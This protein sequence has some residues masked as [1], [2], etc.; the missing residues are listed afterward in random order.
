MYV[1]V[2]TVRSDMSVRVIT[3][4]P[5]NFS[6]V[7]SGV[8]GHQGH[9]GGHVGPLTLRSVRPRHSGEMG[10][11]VVIII[12]PF[13]AA[14]PVEGGGRV[15]PPI[16]RHQWGKLDMRLPIDERIQPLAATC[17]KGLAIRSG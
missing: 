1:C 3:Y 8:A 12:S 15:A 9:F 14:D 13:R 16:V 11:A 4:P 7:R 2:D 10:L 6:S 17:N 5:N